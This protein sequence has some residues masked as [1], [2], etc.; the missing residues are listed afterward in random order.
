M[1]NTMKEDL[2]YLHFLKEDGGYQITKLFIV[3]II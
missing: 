2:A 3:Y 1:N